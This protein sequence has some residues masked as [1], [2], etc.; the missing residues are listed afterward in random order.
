MA[1]QT[2]TIEECVGKSRHH[3]STAVI[4]LMAHAGELTAATV[5][6]RM[7]LIDSNLKPAEEQLAKIRTAAEKGDPA[8]VLRLLDEKF[9]FGHDL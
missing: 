9:E 4:N 6:Y 7:E 5:G 2:G 3:T 1:K 8:E